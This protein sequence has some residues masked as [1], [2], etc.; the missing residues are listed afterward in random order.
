MRA[1]GRKCGSHHRLLRLLIR[2]S[3]IPPA[4]SGWNLTGQWKKI[5]TS[6][7][8]DLPVGSLCRP[9]QSARKRTS[10]HSQYLRRRLPG[11]LPPAG[12]AGTFPGALGA[13]AS[14]GDDKPVITTWSSFPA[15][16]RTN[17]SRDFLTMKI[18]AHQ[19]SSFAFGRNKTLEDEL[20]RISVGA[21]RRL[22]WTPTA[23]QSLWAAFTHALRTPSDGEDDFYRSGYRW[24]GS[25]WA[26]F[27]ARFNA[28]RNLSLGRTE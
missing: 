9:N 3:S 22:L 10:R 6:A 1:A 5:F 26:P 8:D 17:S 16:E 4:L 27:L 7:G 20:Y 18:G 25:G 28:N 13:R 14:K 15:I 24:Y 23:K 11:A 2:R 19:Q 12:T 21:E